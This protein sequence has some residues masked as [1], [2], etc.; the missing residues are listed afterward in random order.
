[1]H[2]L[3]AVAR[4]KDVW[5]R[6][7]VSWLANTEWTPLLTGNPD[8]DEVIS[9]PRSKFRGI[10][11]AWR[12]ARWCREIVAGRA[13]DLTLDF[14]GL[15]RSAIIGRVSKPGAFYGMSDAREGAR[16]FYD[17]VVTVPTGAV[18]AVERYLAFVD[19]AVGQRALRRDLRFPLPLGEAPD[20]PPDKLRPGFVLLHPFARGAGKSLTAPQIELCCRRLSPHRVVLVGKRVGDPFIVPKSAFDLI[21]GTSLLQL[22]WVM[23][24]ASCVISV[25]SGPSHLATA[26]GK[27]MVAIHTWSDPRQVG[28]YRHD[29]WVWKNGQLLKVDQLADQPESFF[30]ASPSSPSPA[31]ID[32][33][34]AL[35]ISLSDSSA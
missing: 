23:R 12:F 31:D 19:G 5:P 25:D 24:R 22:I 14:Q 28:P 35:A 7:R 34:C 13:P 11:G 3:P 8:I 17:R 4:L 27:P 33:I 29:V 30:S 15:L 21:D 18:H 32:A 2:T 10:K 20:E 9:F 6:C 1:M 16:W 26:L